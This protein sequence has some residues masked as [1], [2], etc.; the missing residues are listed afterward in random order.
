MHVYEEAHYDGIADMLRISP[1]T[2]H[3]IASLFSVMGDVLLKD[4]HMGLV[5]SPSSWKTR[6]RIGHGMALG[7]PRDLSR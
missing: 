6:G 2:A 7:K 1:S 4:Q 5:V 3:K